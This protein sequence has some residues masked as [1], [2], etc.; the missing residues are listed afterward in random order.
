MEE[1]PQRAERDPVGRSALDA[2]HELL[3]RI[4]DELKAE[5]SSG[6]ARVDELLERFDLAARAHFLEEQSLMRLHAYPGY[7]PHQNE[8]DELVE[9]L[10]RLSERIRQGEIEDAARTAQELDRWLNVHM[11]TTDA[12]LE[13]YLAKDGIRPGAERRA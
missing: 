13:T 5:L 2:E 3:H 12:A 1:D 8:H 10:R 11:H 9:E 7:E 4:L 6:G